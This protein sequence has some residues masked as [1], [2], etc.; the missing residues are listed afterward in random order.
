MKYTLKTKDLILRDTEHI[1]YNF[2]LS[3]N[4]TEIPYIQESHLRGIM[5]D[6]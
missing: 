6:F 4:K 3:K 1:V 2:H 5:I